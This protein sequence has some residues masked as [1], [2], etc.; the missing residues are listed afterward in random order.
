MEDKYKAAGVKRYEEIEHPSDV[1]LRFRGR[2]LEELFQNAGEGMF[3][4]ITDMERVEPL[5]SLELELKGESRSYEDILIAWLERLLYHFEVD[6]M[7]F[8][9]ILVKQL[10]KSKNSYMLRA[11]LYGDRIDRKKHNI[12]EEIKAPT[13]QFLSICR[14]KERRSWEGTVIFDV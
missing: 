13:Y 9:Q 5:I 2:S 3:S 4:L 6:F 7:L 1:G 12:M 8:S 14:D 10:I 11:V